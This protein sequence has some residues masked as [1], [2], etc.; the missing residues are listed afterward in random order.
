MQLRLASPS[1]GLC[2][3]EVKTVDFT[4]KRKEPLNL[5]SV[6]QKF[7]YDA[8]GRY[9][10]ALDR[11]PHTVIELLLRELHRNDGQGFRE[12]FELSNEPFENTCHQCSYALGL[13]LKLQGFSEVYLLE[14][15]GI[16]ALEA[17]SN[18]IT[19]SAPEPRF[20]SQGLQ[21]NPHCLLGIVMNE[22]EYLVS[23]KHFAIEAHE[24]TSTLGTESHLPRNTVYLKRIIHDTVRQKNNT[25]DP[26]AFPI[27]LKTDSSNRRYYKVFGRIPLMLP[28]FTTTSAQDI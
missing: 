14:C 18:V 25:W 4:D 3:L 19:R 21:H 12:L 23:A 17:T 26:V 6:F 15:Y 22:V 9:Q 10:P 7:S 16:E 24:L 1:R 2:Q 27:W 20:A 5:A 28:E 11:N 8:V 13:L